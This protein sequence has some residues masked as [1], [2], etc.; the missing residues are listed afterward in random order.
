[1]E[2]IRITPYEQQRYENTGFRAEVMDG[3]IVLR[4]L[5]E[6]EKNRHSEILNDIAA[7]FIPR[8]DLDTL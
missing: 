3:K 2:N 7:G 8:L 5:T 4:P 6:E 1:M